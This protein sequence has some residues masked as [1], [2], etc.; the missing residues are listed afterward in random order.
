[1]KKHRM[2]VAVVILLC[3]LHSAAFAIAIGPTASITIGTDTTDLSSYIVASGKGYVLQWHWPPQIPAGISATQAPAWVHLYAGFQPE[4]SVFYM[5]EVQNLGPDPLPVLLTLTTPIVGGPYDQAIGGISFG[6]VGDW[7]G[8][9]VSAT[10]TAPSGHLQIAG[11]APMGN[12]GVD[13]GGVCTGGPGYPG[14]LFPCGPY[15]PVVNTFG[16][17]LFSSLTVSLGFTLTGNEDIAIFYGD[18]EI[19]RVIPEPAG[20]LLAGGGLFAVAL[21]R[22]R[23]RWR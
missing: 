5:F 15:G 16:P 21:L 8:D 1:M 18:A 9:G 11:G 7:T 4:P 20:F 23:R 14:R 12:L 10:P 22:R 17:T 6:E 3:G 19:S 13:V 2:L